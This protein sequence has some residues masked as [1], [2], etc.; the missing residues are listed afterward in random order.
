MT[1]DLA[2]LALAPDRR[3]PGAVLAGP[4]DADPTGA[5]C[6]YRPGRVARPGYLVQRRPG[7]RGGARCSPG[8]AVDLMV[9]GTGELVVTTLDAAGRQQSRRH[10]PGAGRP[11]PGRRTTRSGAGSSW[12]AGPEPARLDS[13]DLGRPRPA[14]A[15]RRCRITAVVPT[16][17]REHEAL[18]QVR[19]LLDPALTDVVARVVLVDQAGTLR[20]APAW[21]KRPPGPAPRLVLLEQDNL[22]GSGGFARGMLEALAFPDDA[23]LL[24][25]DDARSIRRA[26]AG[27]SCCPRLLGGR[28]SRPSWAR[29]CSPPNSPTVLTAA[30]RGSRP[31]RLPVGAGP[32][33][34][35]RPVDLAALGPPAWTFARPGRAHRLRGL[36]G[37]AAAGRGRRRSRA[38]RP[39]LPQVGR[40]GVRT[41]RPAGRA[42]ASAP[43]PVPACWHPTWAAKGTLASWAAMAAAPQ[44]AGHR[45]RLRRR[46][47]ACSPT[48]SRTRSSTS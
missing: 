42:T 16:F 35:A 25:D 22:G 2:R 32:T 46:P 20:A 48:P 33:D 44:P 9:R 7:R 13:L 5:A 41:A 30:R 15:A 1:V 23:V 45:R 12:R 40:R 39:V 4:G 24:L 6:G 37:R 47:R 36:V 38:A 27:C 18:T 8:S 10:R 3:Q 28:P 34:C 31:V 17:R 29:R 14:R 43:F 11:D 19:R 26:C 21:P